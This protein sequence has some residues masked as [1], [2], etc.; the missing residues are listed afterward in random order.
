MRQA[1]KPPPILASLNTP[2]VNATVGLGNGGASV[3]TPDSGGFGEILVY[4]GKGAL[5]AGS[6]SLTFP[7]TPPTLFIAPGSDDFGPIT[8]ATAG[9]V[10][11]ISW[12]VAHFVQRWAPYT[13]HY[14][15]TDEKK[16]N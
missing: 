15:W 10:V 5:A 12:T 9:N 14:E 1:V 4:A 16:A 13:I 7:T 8:Q 6:V 2:A 3:Q 11:T